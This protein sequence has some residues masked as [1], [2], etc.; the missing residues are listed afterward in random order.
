MYMWC[1]EILLDSA[2]D[3]EETIPLQTPKQIHSILM[4]R[5]CSCYAAAS[6]W[7][8]H[9]SLVRGNITDILINLVVVALLVVQYTYLLSAAK[10][11]APAQWPELV[12]R[13]FRAGRPCATDAISAFDSMDIVLKNDKGAQPDCFLDKRGADELFTL[14]GLPQVPFLSHLS[15]LCM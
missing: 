15:R 10:T 9:A 11:L 2:R 4:K 6:W 3:K 13:F 8:Y 14:M 7:S 1:N 5:Y 12:P